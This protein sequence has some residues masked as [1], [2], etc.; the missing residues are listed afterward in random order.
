MEKLK[1]TPPNL[2]TLPLEI[3]LMTLIELDVENQGV[4]HFEE[5]SKDFCTYSRICCTFKVAQEFAWKSLVFKTTQEGRDW[6]TSDATIRGDYETTDLIL[7]GSIEPA[8]IEALLAVMNQRDYSG[9]LNF[10]FVEMNTPVPSSLFQNEKF[11][12]KQLD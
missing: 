12:G 1:T 3:V 5:R 4:L 2:D 6:L 10:L 9:Q 7:K 8:S 11:K